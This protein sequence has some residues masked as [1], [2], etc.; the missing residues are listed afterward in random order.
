MMKK[1]LIAAMLT[2]SLTGFTFPAQ[3]AEQTPAYP[4][5]IDGKTVN[6]DHAAPYRTAQGTV[7][8]PLRLTAEALGYQVIWQQSTKDIQVE[9][10]IQHIIL[11]PNS[12]Q[13]KVKGTL[14]VIDL[15]GDYVLDEKLT[16][17]NGVLYAPATLFEPLFN[18]VTIGKQF[19]DI[20]PSRSYITD[21][22]S[23]LDTGTE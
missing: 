21:T 16:R 11:Y 9:A 8:V 18:D 12:T 10:P 19:V 4:L 6:T 14:K 23:T 22:S 17:K 5:Q 13:M 7:M 3:A 2:C 1:W 20:S 15:S